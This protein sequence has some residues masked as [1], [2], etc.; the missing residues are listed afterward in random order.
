[1]YSAYCII[2]CIH[3]T[4][5]ERKG[6]EKIEPCSR[7]IHSIS[8]KTVRSHHSILVN[9]SRR[10]MKTVAGCIQRKSH[11]INALLNHTNPV[12]LSDAFH[13]ILGSA[14]SKL[15]S[16]DNEIFV[17]ERSKKRNTLSPRFSV[18]HDNEGS[19]FDGDTFLS[20]FSTVLSTKSRGIVPIAST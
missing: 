14:K 1:M 6:I 15:D 7:G 2:Y 13:A 11:L 8:A 19:Q 20:C 18:I 3:S 5:I 4:D 17:K 10:C 16:D 12:V 9:N